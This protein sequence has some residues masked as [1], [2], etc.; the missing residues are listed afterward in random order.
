MPQNDE[1]EWGLDADGNAVRVYPTG[2]QEVQLP[3]MPPL[4]DPQVHQAGMV[5]RAHPGTS[6]DAA[7]LVAPRSG[8]QR[9]RI[10][11]LFVAL[12]EGEGLTADEVQAHSGMAP[13][14]VNPRM[15]ELRDDERVGGWLVD[16]GRKRRTRLGG[17][18]IVWVLAPGAR[19]RFAQLAARP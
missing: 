1:W 5:G 6:R 11:A 8:T 19:A 9:W 4:P 17:D 2:D 10:L 16:S 18:A 15:L 13:Q 12:P 3:G 7:T 14:S